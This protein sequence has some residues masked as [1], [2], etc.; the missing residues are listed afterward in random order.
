MTDDKNAGIFDT[1]HPMR[2]LWPKLVTAEQ[3]KGKGDYKFRASFLFPD[4]HP[5][6]VPL[7]TL[8]AKLAKAKW[9]EAKLSL[10]KSKSDV[11][12]AMSFGATEAAERAANGKDGSLYNGQFVIK[13]TA[14]KDYPPMVASFANGAFTPEVPS[15]DMG[16]LVAKFYSGVDVLAVLNFRAME[17]DRKKYVACYMNKIVSLNTGARIGGGR[18]AAEAFKGYLGKLSAEDPTAGTVADDDDF[19]K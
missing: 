16:P 12:F 6:A 11:S 13:A 17:V 18:S 10:D 7:K 5:D 3:Y 9:P 4:D 14:G 2:L 19:M 15:A 8:L 1:S